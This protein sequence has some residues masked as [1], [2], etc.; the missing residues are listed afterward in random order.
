MTHRRSPNKYYLGKCEPKNNSNVEMTPHFPDLW[1]KNFITRYSLL[2]LYLYMAMEGGEKTEKEKVEEEWLIWLGIGSLGARWTSVAFAKSSVC[3]VTLLV[4]DLPDPKVHCNV[5]L[6]LTLFAMGHVCQVT[7][8]HFSP[9]SLDAF[10][11]Y[12]LYVQGEVASSWKGM[13]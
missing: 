9:K 7:E 2:L 11:D 13:F 4:I 3:Q 5:N 8:P 1:N 10:V 6:C 12:P